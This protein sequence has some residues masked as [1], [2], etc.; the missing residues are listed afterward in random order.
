MSTEQWQTCAKDCPEIQ[1]LHG[2]PAANEDLES[3]D[4]PTEFLAA[5]LIFQTDA[6][7]QGNL[8][9]ECE[10]TFAELPEQQKLTKLCSNAGFLENPL[11]K[12]SFSLHL[13]MM[14]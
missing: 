6:E 10:Q 12:D 11:R 4:I 14:T 7:V 5:N 1:R 3:L 2:K 9:R 13:M 8:L